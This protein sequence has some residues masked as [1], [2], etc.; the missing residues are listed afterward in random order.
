MIN[1][2]YKSIF[3][4]I[5]V[6]TTSFFLL[7]G[8]GGDHPSA[9]K[10]SKTTSDS[11][12]P[13]AA[14]LLHKGSLS[15][16]LQIPGE[17]AS[18]QKVDIYAKVNSFVKKVLVDVGTRVSKG[19]LLAQLE[20]PE[21]SSQLSAA[22]SHLQS[23]QATYMA[24][25]AYYNRLLETSKTPGTVS[26]NDLE[27]AMA[28]R[29]SDYAQYLA[30]KANYSEITVQRDYL[31]VRAPFD[32]IVSARN[33]NPGAYVGPSGS[34]DALPML[35]VQQ[36]KHLRLVISVPEAYSNMLKLGDMVNFTTRSL[37]GQVF[38]ATVARLAGALDTK[39]R[40]ERTEMNVYSDGA[41]LPGM[42]VEVNIPMPSNN[43]S[44]VVPRAALVNS[45]EGVYVIRVVGGK[46]QHVP[47]IT[48]ISNDDNIQIF[49]KL[50]EN[51]QI[52]TNGSEELRDGGPAAKLIVE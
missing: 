3:S 12:P 8:C 21:I 5:L 11:V 45:T 35:T 18:Y 27:Q 34:G 24:S 13:E 31:T 32:G 7:T 44:F 42:T 50:N 52:I 16:T 1:N 10:K 37:P 19:Q 39:L 2:H 51:D 29:N 9:A 26:S 25:R 40:A 6:A 43:S 41:L 49:G 22:S 20:A 15:D 17:L 4:G 48:G 33:I 30:N 38:H 36:Q 47:V 14:F 23:M 46:Y 28:K